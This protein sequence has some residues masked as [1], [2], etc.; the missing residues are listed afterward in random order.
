MSAELARAEFYAGEVRDLCIEDPEAAVF[1]EETTGQCT[2]ETIYA[3]ALGE[4]EGAGGEDLTWSI[5]V[6][7]YDEIMREAPRE[8][9]AELDEL[10][11]QAAD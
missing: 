6:E 9:S 2:T 11:I 4:Y 1:V 10:L 3:W 5:F 8:R 7:E